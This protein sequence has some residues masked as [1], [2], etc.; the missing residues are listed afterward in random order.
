MTRFPELRDEE[1]DEEQRRVAAAIVGG[2]RGSMQG[3][4][5]ALLHSPGLADRVQSLGAWLRFECS[6]PADLKELAIILTA[7][8]WTAQFE[9]YAH[10]RFALE[11][12][13]GQDIVS[14]IAEGRRPEGL[15][16]VRAA[17][18]DLCIELLEDGRVSDATFRRALD[19]LDRRSLM[20]LVGLC[21]YY[22]LIAMVLNV[23]EVPI[24]DGATPLAEPRPRP[25]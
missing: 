5:S 23:A 20:D 10:S 11:A 6:L 21:G 18:H 17:V 25:A 13:I 7:R 8:R 22:T 19:H 2:P 12:G 3:P 15:S 16:P 14:A 9:W 4:F 1:L 24:P